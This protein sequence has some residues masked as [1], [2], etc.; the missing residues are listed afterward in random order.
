M[1]PFNPKDHPEDNL[2][3]K[4]LIDQLSKHGID[5]DLFFGNDQDPYPNHRIHYNKLHHLDYHQNVFSRQ[6][7]QAGAVTVIVNPRVVLLRFNNL[8][9]RPDTGR[10]EAFFLAR[11]ILENKYSEDW[12]IG[13][14]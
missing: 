7:K 6:S 13:L 11:I 5:P 10:Y 2:P 8:C 12:V 1:I 4:K 9:P 14:N 3:S